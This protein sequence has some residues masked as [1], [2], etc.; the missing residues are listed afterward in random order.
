MKAKSQ[1]IFRDLVLLILKEIM[2]K[3]KQLKWKNQLNKQKMSIKEDSQSSGEEFQENEY[4]NSVKNK[5][6]I[7]LTKKCLREAESDGN[8]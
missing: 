7:K 2:Q 6:F 4:R 3:S 5:N 8:D 1:V